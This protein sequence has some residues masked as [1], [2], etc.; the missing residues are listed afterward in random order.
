MVNAPENRGVRSGLV[1]RATRDQFNGGR[2]KYQD[3]D[4]P[5]NCECVPDHGDLLTLQL[6]HTIVILLYANRI[7]KHYRV[8]SY[9]ILN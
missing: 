9:N 3:N 1:A 5:A 2:D 6:F 8:V 7:S 4:R